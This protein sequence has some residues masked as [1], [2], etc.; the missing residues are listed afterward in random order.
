MGGVRLER[1]ALWPNSDCG[2][3]TRRGTSSRRPPTRAYANA[4]LDDRRAA[5]LQRQV[6][7]AVGAEDGF[8]DKRYLARA[9]L[10][11]FVHRSS[12]NGFANTSGYIRKGQR[13]R[14]GR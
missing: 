10:L 11:L 5:R 4:R 6:C 13:D 14:A 3:A 9:A 7:V 12:R 8:V 1:G 2:T